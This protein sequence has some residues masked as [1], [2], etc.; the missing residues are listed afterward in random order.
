VGNLTIAPVVVLGIGSRLCCVHLMDV[1]STYVPVRLTDHFVHTRYTRRRQ[2][3]SLDR[4]FRSVRSFAESF[5][6]LC[7]RWCSQSLRGHWHPAQNRL[8]ERRSLEGFVS[9]LTK[10]MITDGDGVKVTV[11][12][13]FNTRLIVVFLLRL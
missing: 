6:E 4:S 3:R 5:T 1:R 11:I 10:R 7:K 8:Y 13:S 12:T 9:Y 2:Y